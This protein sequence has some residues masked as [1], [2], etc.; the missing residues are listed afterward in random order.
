MAQYCTKC[1]NKTMLMS[2][3]IYL[4]IDAEPYE[5]GVEEP[6]KDGITDIE[7]HASAHYCENCDEVTDVFTEE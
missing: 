7:R 3:T 4:N 5:S 6:S 2:G 1:G